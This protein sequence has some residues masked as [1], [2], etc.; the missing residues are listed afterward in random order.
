MCTCVGPS[1]KKQNHLSSVSSPRMIFQNGGTLDNSDI[2]ND[3]VNN[4]CF[5][6]LWLR[7]V[8]TSRGISWKW[9]SFKETETLSPDLR[10]TKSMMTAPD[11][12]TKKRQIRGHKEED[13]ERER[14]DGERAEREERE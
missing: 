12:R 10:S 9:Y 7:A 3:N 8:D 13:G 11:R 4:G 2:S 14:K 5:S 1:N 6:C